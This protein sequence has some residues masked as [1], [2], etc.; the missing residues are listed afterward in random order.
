MKASRMIGA[1][2]AAAALAFMTLTAGAD[3]PAARARVGQAA[4]AFSLTAV[5]GSTHSLEQY[6]GK[7]VVLEWF[8][9]DCPFV[10]KHHQ[11]NKT[12]K[13]L[14][15]RYADRDVVWLAINSGAEGK[16][17]AGQERNARAVREYGIEYPMLLDPT[18]ATGRAYGAVCTP[19]MFV[20]DAQG[21]LR[22]QGAIDDDRD[23]RQLGRTNYVAQAL[24]AVLGGQPVETAE[25]RP[26][27]CSVKYGSGAP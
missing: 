18:G 6:K 11:H 17:G 20:I 21:V 10:K 1:G 3:E 15:A 24:D 9:P 13:E 27:G 25:T 4:P 5:D 16:Q 7:V 2:V 14:A 19:H 23:A 22:Y 12:M 26:Y 8:N